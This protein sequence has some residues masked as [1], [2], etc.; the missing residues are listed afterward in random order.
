MPRR[1][2]IP[3]SVIG[4]GTKPRNSDCEFRMFS[5]L[6][7][8]GL[9]VIET[10]ERLD[11]TPCNLVVPYQRL[12]GTCCVHLQEKNVGKSLLDW[13]FYRVDESSSFLRNFSNYLADYMAVIFV[14]GIGYFFH[15]AIRD[16][17]SVSGSTVPHTDNNRQNIEFISN[18]K[19][20]WELR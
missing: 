20:L 19:R 14:R 2:H 15:H 10:G 18:R 1:L 16:N 6:P 9:N 8:R 17:F 4:G 11:M 5:L 12:R 13:E 7:C 3:F